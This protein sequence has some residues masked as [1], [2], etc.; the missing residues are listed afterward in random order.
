MILQGGG[1]AV[2]V[3]FLEE[4]YL[5]RGSDTHGRC[6]SRLNKQRC[7]YN[8]FKNGYDLSG[9]TVNYFLD[10]GLNKASILFPGVGCFLVAV[11]IGSFCH[12]SNDAD[13]KA[14]FVLP[15]DAG[16]AYKY[17]TLML[18]WVFWEILV[19]TRRSRGG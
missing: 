13:T 1:F 8:T 16:P 19:L 2:L 12:A 17:V 3:S 4:R 6:L 11:I 10:E 18:H 15:S 14:K 9:T 7:T 5:V